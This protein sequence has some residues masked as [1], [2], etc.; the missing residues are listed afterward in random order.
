MWKKDYWNYTNIVP[1]WLNIFI[2][3]YSN[4]RHVG[5]CQVN[6]IKVIIVNIESV[7]IWKTSFETVLIWK[8]CYLLQI[9]FTGKLM[10][11][12]V[13]SPLLCIIIIIKALTEW[14]ECSMQ[15][16]VS[17]IL[18]KKAILRHIFQEG[19]FA[20]IRAKI[21]VIINTFLVLANFHFRK[22]SG[23]KNWNS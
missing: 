3:V 14:V 7:L 15:H 12:L 23:H 21:G 11:Y 22:C 13:C 10:W 4:V 17:P 8:S 19:W 2:G 9:H 16:V 5:W 20:R 18:H 6:E 1:N